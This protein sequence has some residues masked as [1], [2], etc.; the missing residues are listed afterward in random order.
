MKN[1]SFYLEEVEN[2]ALNMRVKIKSDKYLDRI[3]KRCFS[4]NPA[5]LFSLFHLPIWWALYTLLPFITLNK[6]YKTEGAEPTV[7]DNLVSVSY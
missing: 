2:D 6:C 3:F 1:K 7:R 4:H 5:V